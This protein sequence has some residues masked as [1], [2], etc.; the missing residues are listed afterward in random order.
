MEKKINVQISQGAVGSDTGNGAA[1]LIVVQVPGSCI[2]KE[3]KL[4]GSHER[5]T[6][7][8]EKSGEQNHKQLQLL[9]CFRNQR[10]GR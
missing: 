1:Q 5:L 2:G 10:L 3:W 8:R 7:G 6:Q 4:R 9:T